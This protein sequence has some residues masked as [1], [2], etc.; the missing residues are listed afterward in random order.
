MGYSIALL[1]IAIVASVRSVPKVWTGTVRDTELFASGN[2]PSPSSEKVH[3]TQASPAMGTPTS[4]T[5]TA[6]NQQQPYHAL[7]QAPGSH[8]APYVGQV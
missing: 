6:V 2:A 3:M 1:I 7:P 5:A 8:P 4:T